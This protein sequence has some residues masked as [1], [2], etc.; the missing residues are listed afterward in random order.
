M[1]VK[2][3]KAKGECKDVDKQAT[4]SSFWTTAATATAA[5]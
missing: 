2:F 3:S 1:R 5:T 4:I